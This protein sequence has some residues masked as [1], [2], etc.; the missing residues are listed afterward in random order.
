MFIKLIV[1]LMLCLSS[2][3]A[4]AWGAKGHQ[5]VSMVGASLSDD[6]QVFWGA[7]VNAFRQL[8]TVPDRTW[9]SN[10]FKAQEGHQHF[11]QV[12][13][14]YKSTEYDQIITFPGSYATAVTK[15]SEREILRNGTTPWRIRQLYTMAVQQF[16]LG[17][18]KAGLELAGTM[19]HYIA[20]LSQPLHVTENFNGQFSGNS[21][22]HSYF[23]TTIITDEA[24]VRAEVSRR[25]QDLLRDPNFLTQFKRPLMDVILLEIERSIAYKD[26]VL[27]NDNDFGRTPQGAAVQLEL[28]KDRMADGAAT[29]ALILGQLWKDTRLVA[30]ATPVPIEDPEWVVPDFRNSNRG[31]F[32]SNA[33]DCF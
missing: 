1:S 12:D 17:N 5:I 14:Y 4:L 6:G 16:Q 33:A 27:K 22:I 31:E 25:A 11:F 13:A 32:S 28:A 23:E 29:L 3:T 21:G 9:K 15:Y 10:Q 7:N 19:S 20:D 24:A 26:Q 18:M 8:S 30:N 2:A